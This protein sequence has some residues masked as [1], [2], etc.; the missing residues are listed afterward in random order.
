MFRAAQGVEQLAQIDGLG[1]ALEQH[2]EAQDERVADA[3][4]KH[5]DCR[6]NVR[7]VDLPQKGFVATE[8]LENLMFVDCR[9]NDD[10]GGMQAGQ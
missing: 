4:S 1:V 2:G 10:A 7:A 9:R 3:S 5:P 6:G 8:R